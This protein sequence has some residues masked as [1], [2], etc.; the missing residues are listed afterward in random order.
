MVFRY[1]ATGP[2]AFFH[3]APKLDFGQFK[4]RGR[5]GRMKLMLDKAAKSLRVFEHEH[6]INRKRGGSCAPG[7]NNVRS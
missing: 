7:A 3:K 6:D 2:S 5:V 4:R 1:D